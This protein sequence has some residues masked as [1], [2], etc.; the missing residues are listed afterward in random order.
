MSDNQ[1]SD[2]KSA[3]SGEW[4]KIVFL[5]AIVLTVSLTAYFVTIKNPSTSLSPDGEDEDR[6]METAGDRQADDASESPEG[7]PPG[8]APVP[9]IAKWS[10]YENQEFGFRMAFPPDWRVSE[11]NQRA[12]V[13]AFEPLTVRGDRFQEQV[14]VG[15]HK[16][17]AGLGLDEAFQR[18]LAGMKNSRNEITVLSIGEEV[19]DGR[20]AKWVLA[21]TR[22]SALEIKAIQYYTMNNDTVYI[23]NCVATP[24]TFDSYA[25]LFL[26]VAETFRVERNQ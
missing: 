5:A 12:V 6:T 9:E 13:S 25:D 20:T 26:K 4:L 16:M 18:S 8:P 19:L 15:V 3:G 2:K 7:V 23:I 22:T 11:E 14:T 21:S 24:E 17:D 10:G 1:N